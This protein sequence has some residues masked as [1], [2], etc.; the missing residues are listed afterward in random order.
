MYAGIFNR[1]KN[2]P[3]LISVLESLRKQFPDLHFDVAGDGGD[4]EKQV[5]ELMNAHRDWISYH[6]KITDLEE[7]KNL[8]RANRIFVMPSKSE[9]FGLVYVEAMS[10][11]LS[12]MWSRGEAIDGMFP[13]HI[14]ESVNPL[15]S[16]DIHE[17]LKKLLSQSD[18][19]DTLPASTFESFRWSSIAQKYISL[20]SNIQITNF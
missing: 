13:E 19:Y 18:H 9:T 4:N 16:N 12:V 14:G 3:R 8:Y 11:G 10:Q 17:K 1:N 7:M 2:L 20:Y 5:L 15:N 6:G